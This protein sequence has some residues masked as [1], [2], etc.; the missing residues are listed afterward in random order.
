MAASSSRALITAN[1]VRPSHGE[2]ELQPTKIG[3]AN[4]QRTCAIKIGTELGPNCPSRAGI[5]RNGTAGAPRSRAYRYGINWHDP[6]QEGTRR[7]PEKQGPN[8]FQD[9]CLKPLGHPSLASTPMERC[10]RSMAACTWNGAQM[11]R[12]AGS[13]DLCGP[14]TS[15]SP[16]QHRC[17]FRRG[18]SASSFRRRR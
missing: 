6:G 14:S 11:R 10:V 5:E 8:G 3:L 15:C 18:L 4:D 13:Y 16:L 17:M 7:Y 2:P 1:R 12:A 9:R